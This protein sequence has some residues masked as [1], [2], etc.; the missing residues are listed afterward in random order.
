MVKEFLFK[1]ISIDLDDGYKQI[2]LI[3]LLLVYEQIKINSR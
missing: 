2:L 1:Q 3:K